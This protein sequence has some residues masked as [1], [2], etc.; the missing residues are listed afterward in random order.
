M[1]EQ[2]WTPAFPGQRTPFEAG[3]EAAV[4][5]GAY[6]PA[7]LAPRAQ[8]IERDLRAVVPTYSPS[9]EHTVRL[10]ALVLARVE[11]ANEWLFEHGIFRNAKGEPQPIL[12]AL[13][14]WENSAA[15]LYDRLGLTP[16]A[17]AALGLQPPDRPVQDLD[18][19]LAS[20]RSGEAGRMN[21]G[22]ASG[23]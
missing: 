6:S 2:E 14:T 20:K 18:A 1:G 16:T 17:R 19:Y 4:R 15:R 11:A 9:D 21:E 8:A 13:S 12:K 23:H 7:K 3:N 10:L 22:T 5:H